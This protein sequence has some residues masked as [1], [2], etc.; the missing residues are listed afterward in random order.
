MTFTFGKDF[1]I[2]VF[3]ESHGEA[4][5]V[6][7]EGCIPGLEI[8]KTQIQRNLNRRRP[9]SSPLVSSRA[10]SDIVEIHSGVFNDRATGAPIMMTIPN[11]DVDSSS[12]EE[13]KHTPRPGHA[14]YTARIKYDG[15]NDYRGGGIFSGR[16]TAALVMAGSIAERILLKKSIEVI[17]H[18]VQI[19]SVR[20]G[21]SIT[22]AEIKSNVYSNEVRCAD[23]ESVGPMLEEVSKAKHE[24]DSIGGIIE[25]RILGVPVG[26][27][28]PFFD[29]VESV[30]SHAMFSIPGAKGIEFGSGFHAASMRGSEHNDSPQVDNGKVTWIKNDAGGVLGG[31]TNGAPVV[32]RV[33]FK[34]TS[35]ISKEQRTVNLE[36]MVETSLKAKGRHD[37]CIVPRALPV[38]EGLACI[39]IA[40]LVKRKDSST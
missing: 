26:I 33:G 19:G 37:P 20:A 29:S 6:V 30:I 9:G 17:A 28:E 25:C 8:D 34:P 5:G 40:D 4:I 7:V 32:F 18:V 16:M 27:G 14:D 24:G 21:R 38:V 12:Y 31:I 2:Q 36:K 13:M 22:D 3:G 35:T 11:T 10:E 23:I 39:A 15:Y 1:K